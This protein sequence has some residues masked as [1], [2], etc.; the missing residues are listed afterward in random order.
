MVASRLRSQLGQ[1]AR[2][3]PGIA[4]RV[5]PWVQ[6]VPEAQG[7]PGTQGVPEVH[8]VPEAEASPGAFGVKGSWC[9]RD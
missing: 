2:G 8:G 9:P 3:N 5:W 7:I 4:G 1:G 6:G